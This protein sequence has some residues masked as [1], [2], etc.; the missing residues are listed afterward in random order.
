MST[1][2]IDLEQGRVTHQHHRRNNSETDDE[3]KA[4]ICFSEG[5]C[6]STFYSTAGGSYEDIRFTDHE[7]GDGSGSRRDSSVSD[8]SV[9]IEI[10]C[11]DGNVKVH[12]D[13]EVGGES[14]E[15]RICHLSLGIGSNVIELGCDC[16]N[17][18]AAAHSN[19]AERWFKIRGNRTCEICNSIAE[20][21]N[22]VSEL[23]LMQQ[24]T[25][26]DASTI[27]TTSLA[28][29]SPAESTRSF[30]QGRR[31]LNILLACMVFTFIMSRLFHFKVP[32]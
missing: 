5:S 30:W 26:T 21:V 25:A 1:A 13:E 4:S 20:N 19:C 8:C 27:V 6:Y 28:P 22:V 2:H 9:A 24:S 29:P 32:S 23:E 7:V 17:D 14:R 12:L 3:D 10:H 18:L 31:F 11:G 16:K 15:C